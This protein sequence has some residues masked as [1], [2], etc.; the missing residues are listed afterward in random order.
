M[1]N[2]FL[3]IA[4]LTST[5]FADDPKFRVNLGVSP[6]LMIDN[7]GNMTLG[8]YTSDNTSSTIVSR[9]A[10][11]NFSAGTI[12][13]SLTGHASLDELAANV[14]A[15]ARAAAVSDAIVNGVLNIAPS[16]NAVFDALALKYD[17][18]NP[19]SYVDAAGARSATL[20]SSTYMVGPGR[21]YST[22]QAALTAIGDGASLADLKTPKAVFIAGGVYNEDLT[23]PRGRIITLYA[24]GTV[25]LGNGAGTNWSS[26]VTRNVTATFNNADAFGGDIKPALNIIGMPQSDATSTFV[27]E[28]GTFRISGNLVIA[29]DGLSNTVNLNSVEID[30]QLNQTTAGLI[31]LQGYKLLVKGTVNAGTSAVLERCYDCQFDSL[32]TINAINMMINSEIKAGLTV[33]TVQSNLPPNGFF[34]TTITGTFTGPANSARFDDTTNYFF[35]INGASLGGSATKVLIHDTTVQNISKRIKANMRSRPT[36]AYVEY[37]WWSRSRRHSASLSK[38]CN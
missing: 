18:T 22:I 19:S 36:R 32:L 29:G 20:G 28:A 7:G 11:G 4:L 5:A 12:T 9:D 33:S 15:D 23:I 24:E 26:T 1:K 38:R 2:I 16:Q 13:A 25:I 8:G 10:S 27:A 3:I 35:R 37:R 31:N 34:N 14:A 17:A 30:G 6:P 21:Q